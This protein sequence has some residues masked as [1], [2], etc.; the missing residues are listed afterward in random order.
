MISV[1]GGAG[2]KLNGDI[3]KAV[4]VLGLEVPLQEQT[5]YLAAVLGGNVATEQTGDGLL[6][7]SGIL[8]PEG[9]GVSYQI[10]SGGAQGGNV[11]SIRLNGREYSR[12]E[13]GLNIV[14]YSIETGRVLD[15]AAFEE[16]EGVHGL[17]FNQKDGAVE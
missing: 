7:A 15:E 14:V 11:S 9:R 4:R 17:L 13:T 6:E 10:T 12:N 5:G 2:A 1:K 8:D 16:N 3:A